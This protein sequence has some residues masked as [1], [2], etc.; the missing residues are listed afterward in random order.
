MRRT[1]YK[2]SILSLKKSSVITSKEY[3]FL[4]YE[5]NNNLWEI[6]EVIHKKDRL[7]TKICILHLVESSKV[8]CI[9][10]ND[11]GKA[12][13]HNTTA[14]RKAGARSEHVR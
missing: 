3:I 13:K 1:P 4:S 6:K 10:E 12:A 5:K 8:E 11:G 9:S 14:E 7:E 2:V